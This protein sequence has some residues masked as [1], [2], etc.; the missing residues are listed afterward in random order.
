M[1]LL[2]ARSRDHSA[3]P[4]TLTVTISCAGRAV[5]RQARA[6]IT[7]EIAVGLKRRQSVGPPVNTA[8]QTGR[9]APSASCLSSSRF[10]SLQCLNPTGHGSE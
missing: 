1:S 9:A 6:C 5:L 3:A 4:S 2:R 8:R 7:A 10:M